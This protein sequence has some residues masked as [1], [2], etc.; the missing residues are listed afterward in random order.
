[1]RDSLSGVLSRM[2]PTSTDGYILV[3]PP[4][5]VLFVDMRF[6]DATSAEQLASTGRGLQDQFDMVG[7][8]GLGW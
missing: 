7:H 8:S 6:S 4:K 5:Y 1:M 2:P 3:D